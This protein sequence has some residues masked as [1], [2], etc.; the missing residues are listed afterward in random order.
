M[1]WKA[2]IE[3]LFNLAG[4]YVAVLLIRAAEAFFTQTPPEG[5]VSESAFNAMILLVAYE[6]YKHRRF[7]SYPKYSP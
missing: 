5:Q 2:A 4:S 6:F 1:D 7:V 3:V